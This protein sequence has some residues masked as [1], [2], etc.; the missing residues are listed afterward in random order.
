MTEERKTAKRIVEAP[1][2]AAPM[3]PGDVLSVEVGPDE[4]VEWIWSHDPER[5]STVTGYQIVARKAKD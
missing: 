3:S 1:D 2:T 5:G 4:D